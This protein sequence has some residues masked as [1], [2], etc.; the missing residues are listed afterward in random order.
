MKNVIE[1]DSKKIGSGRTGLAHM[2][3]IAVQ[4]SGV[5]DWCAADLAVAEEEL[6]KGWHE[7]AMII[8]NKK[9]SIKKVGAQDQ[10]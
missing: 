6:G 4:K 5:D 9:Q 10:R 1:H 8:Y 3:L 7:E 2:M